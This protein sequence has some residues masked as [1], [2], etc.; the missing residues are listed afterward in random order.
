MSYFNFIRTINLVILLYL[1]V[2]ALSDS[3]ENLFEK[4]KAAEDWNIHGILISNYKYYKNVI[5]ETNAS[6][7]GV[8]RIG[9]IINNINILIIIIIIIIIIIVK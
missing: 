3:N 2:F 8:R 9:A 6:N 4:T 5:R 7:L 1:F